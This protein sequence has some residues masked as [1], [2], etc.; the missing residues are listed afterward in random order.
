MVKQHRADEAATTNKSKKE[1]NKTSQRVWTGF[2]RSCCKHEHRD[3]SD[4]TTAATPHGAVGP[5]SHHSQKGAQTSRAVVPSQK[6]IAFFLNTKNSQVGPSIG[7]FEIGTDEVNL[8]FLEGMRG[9]IKE[10][11][12]D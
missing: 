5:F 12:S 4:G 9:Q 8:D 10:S 6:N 7:S 1:Q 2:V 11:L 3:H